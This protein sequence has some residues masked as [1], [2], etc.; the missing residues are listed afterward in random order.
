MNLEAIAGADKLRSLIHQQLKEVI[1]QQDDFILEPFLRD[2][3]AAKEI[4]RLQTVDEQKKWSV[5]FQCHGCILCDTRKK[6]YASDGMCLTCR[7]RTHERLQAILRQLNEGRGQAPAPADLEQIAADTFQ[8]VVKFL[9]SPRAERTGLVRPFD[10]EDF[11]AQSELLAR[12][13]KEEIA[14]LVT[15]KDKLIFEPFFRSRQV[16]YELQR[17]LTVPERK[18]WGAYYDAWGCLRCRTKMK[19]HAGTGFCGTC[20]TMLFHRLNLILNRRNKSLPQLPENASPPARKPSS[21]TIDVT[22]IRIEGGSKC[23]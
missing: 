14:E 12:L 13:V 10:P 7:R 15:Q 3:A 11:D 16:S 18:K 23:E 1:A 9:P 22:P 20:K 19:T 2:S 4:R 21:R 8:S 17:L 5:Y 6:L